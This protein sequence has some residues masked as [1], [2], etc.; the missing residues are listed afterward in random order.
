MTEHTPDAERQN[1]YERAR[2]SEEPGAHSGSESQ[3]RERTVPGTASAREGHHQAGTGSG[4]PL[5]GVEAASE[6]EAENDSETDS[7]SGSR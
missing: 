2:N 3:A 1:A 6:E 7:G 4:E 5:A